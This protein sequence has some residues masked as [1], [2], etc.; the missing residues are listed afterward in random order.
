[1]SSPSKAFKMRFPLS[2]V[3]E[4][5]TL[6]GLYMLPLV[7][8]L[9]HTNVSFFNF[10]IQ[11]LRYCGKFCNNSTPLSVKQCWDKNSLSINQQV[12]LPSFNLE[13][14]YVMCL[15]QTNKED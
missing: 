4:S 6:I 14:K 10:V 3:Y 5:I 7:V 12:F 13:L 2:F 8:Y 11:W 9:I 1:M 15:K